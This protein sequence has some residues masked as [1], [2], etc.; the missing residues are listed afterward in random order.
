[1][2]SER[3]VIALEGGTGHTYRCVVC[4][5]RQRMIS[6]NVCHPSSHNIDMS[7]FIEDV[8]LRSAARTPRANSI[9]G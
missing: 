1:M 5:A 4:L 2:G 7:E 9:Q 3:L 8:I 6:D